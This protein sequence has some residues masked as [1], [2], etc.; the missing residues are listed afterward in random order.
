MRS[1]NRR[2]RYTDIY[3]LYIT[4]Y[5]LQTRHQTILKL[6]DKPASLPVSFGQSMTRQQK[7]KSSQKLFKDENENENPTT[8]GSNMSK[9]NISCHS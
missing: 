8:H 6:C 5:T 2:Y 9:S 7:F 4:C 3:R 1:E